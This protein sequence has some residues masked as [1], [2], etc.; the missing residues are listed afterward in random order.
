VAS[1]ANAL[2]FLERQNKA[3]VL[4]AGFALIFL[5]GIIDFATGYEIGLSIFYVLPISMV[6][7][8]VD[9]RQGIIASVASAGVWLSAD[10]AT[11]HFYSHPLI[12][13]WNTIIRLTFFII[14][15]VLLSVLRRAMQR[16]SELAQIDYLTGAANRR[17][18]T[19]LAQSEIDRC[20]R[21][22]RPFSLVY[23][24]ID[25]FK[26]INDNF[27]HLIGDQVLTSVVS[28]I[29][30]NMRKTDQIARLGGDEF[31][32]LLP[33]TGQKSA[34]VALPKLQQQ[35]TAEMQQRNWPV[36]FSIGVLTCDVAPPSINMLLETA[37]EL[38][39]SVKKS[40]K[41]SI[42]FGTYPEPVGNH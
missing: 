12:P 21:Y 32:L 26:A 39:Y 15:T 30:K 17:F 7:W 16:E 40:D 5:I 27:G 18:F 31:A 10:V 20:Q 28:L 2:R 6:T 3:I 1:T 11:G 37:D 22:Q 9:R 42:K 38:M 25:N 19:Y 36:T 23:I 24:D 29:K 35:L 41:N 8:I 33:E 4:L 34:E 13:V 14:I